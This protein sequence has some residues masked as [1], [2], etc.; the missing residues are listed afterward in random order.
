MR[1]Q[2]NGATE[3]NSTSKKNRRSSKSV[4]IDDAERCRCRKIENDAMKTATRRIQA[5]DVLSP[6]NP[7]KR[8][9]QTICEEVNNAFGTNINRKTA[10]RMVKQ[11]HIGVSP[12]KPGPTGRCPSHM[13]KAMKKAFVSYV[14]LELAT[15]KKQ[16]TLKEYSLRVNT[17]V[18]AGGMNKT[19]NRLTMKL[20][21]ET[22]DQL[23]VNNKNGME[24]RRIMWTSHRT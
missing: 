20:K 22:V 18:N 15:N 2:L 9:H 12:S 5:N 8:T 13:W 21:K 17:L 24:Q 1:V 11:G 14:K 3:D 16:S 4:Q 19:G 6:S 23:E 7:R 10:G